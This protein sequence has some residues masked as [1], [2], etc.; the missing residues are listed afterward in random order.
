ML[1]RV[2]QYVSLLWALVLAVADYNE[3]LEVKKDG[4]GDM[5]IS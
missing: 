1:V 2:C 3:G 4:K 5:F